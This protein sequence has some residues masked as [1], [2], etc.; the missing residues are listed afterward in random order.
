MKV[1]LLEETVWN[2]ARASERT[3]DVARETTTTTTRDYSERGRSEEGARK[4]GTRAAGE[5]YNMN[6]PRRSF[7][8]L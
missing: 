1:V 2:R 4:R 7:G 5:L 6:A 8:R 3:V